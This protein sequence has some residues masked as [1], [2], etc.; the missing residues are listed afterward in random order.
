VTRVLHLRASSGL[1]GPERWLLETAPALA[2]EGFEIAICLLERRT[3]TTEGFLEEARELGI[4]ATALPDPGRLAGTTVRG[5]AEIA[6]RSRAVALHAHDVKSDWLALAASRR[7]GRPA[8]AT[9]HLH[10]RGS[11]A[12][13][14]Y[15]WVD[16]TRLR[17]FDR[18]FAVSDAVA[19]EIFRWVPPERLRVVRNGVD[20][21]RLEARAALEA[22][23]ARTRLLTAGRGPWLVAAGRLARQKGIDRLLEALALGGGALEGA[24]LALIGAGPERAAL[25][26]HARRLGVDERLLWLG[27]RRDVAGFLAAADLVVLPSR[28]EGLPFVALEALALGRPVV[29]TAVG[30]L[31][32]L[33]ASAGEGWLVRGGRPT[34]LAAALRAALDD[35]EEAARRGR[36]G[37]ERV[38]RELSAAAT[39]RTTAAAYRE[40]LT[41]GVRA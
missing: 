1:A 20:A 6:R 40:A 4:H 31:P 12:L 26:R 18:V 23:A 5:V 19:R 14:F 36:A 22:Q 35:P 25:E 3:G 13:R 41:P 11:L 37:R 7:S 39:A 28:R 27:E 38:R 16:L 34:E 30:G 24:R 10:T 15:R 17:R 29:A 9:V 2:A 8:F 33:I 21:S 32:E